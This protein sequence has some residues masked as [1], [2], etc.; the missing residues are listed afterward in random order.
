[1]TNE[2]LHNEER[3][4]GRP[5]LMAYG[6]V[7]LGACAALVIVAEIG[8]RIAGVTYPFT[9]QRDDNRG[10]ARL[11]GISFWQT[12]EGEAYV[13]I[14]RAGFRDSDRPEAKPSGT[15]RIA[16]LGDSMVEALQVPVEQRFTELTEATLNANKCLGAARTEVLNFGTSGDGTA[17]EL[18]ILRHHA[19]QYSPDLVVLFFMTGNDL[20]NNS[21]TLM[22]DDG[23]P[24]FVLE[25]GDLVLDNSFRTSPSHLK[26]RWER[27]GYR[28]IEYSRLGQLAYKA[29]GTWQKRQRISQVVKTAG[30]PQANVGLDP[31]VYRE[32]QNDEWREAWAVTEALLS[33]MRDEVRARGANF[34]VVT[35]TN[36]TQVDPDLSVRQRMMDK[37]GVK[38]LSY[39]DDRI[40]AFSEREGFDV[41]NLAPPMQDLVKRTGVYFHGFANTP[42]GAGHWNQ[43]GHRVVAELLA[44]AICERHGASYTSSK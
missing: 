40:K 44:K 8:L 18:L 21:K 25:N 11:P 13:T 28:V 24:Y 30:D 43:E 42:K 34:L 15:F 14:N 36:T 29:R 20:R 41:V 27:L 4:A 38:T 35:T 3:A 39:P 22:N 10:T 26:T 1:M 33:L 12:D 5:S 31:L 2:A 37:L 9:S 19:W 17:Q 32:P 16:V 7:A 6:I 23:R